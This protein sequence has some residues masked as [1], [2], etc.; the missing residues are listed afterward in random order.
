MS[1]AFYMHSHA[2]PLSTS[3]VQETE[4]WT[5]TTLQSCGPQQ[6]AALGLSRHLCNCVM[7]CLRGPRRA[8]AISLSRMVGLWFLGREDPAP[9]LCFYLK[10]LFLKLWRSNITCEPPFW[11]LTLQCET[12]FKSENI[13]FSYLIT[14]FPFPATSKIFPTSPPSSYFQNYPRSHI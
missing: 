2:F 1:S 13:I 10:I 11:P 3:P 7:L 6:F 8:H 5:C 4:D 12:S 14:V 9:T